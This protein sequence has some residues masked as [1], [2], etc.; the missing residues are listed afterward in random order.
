MM[1]QRGS[2]DTE[3][4]E[5]ACVLCTKKKAS[6]QISCFHQVR[7][8]GSGGQSVAGGECASGGFSSVVSQ[9]LAGNLRHSLSASAVRLLEFH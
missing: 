3:L 9:L 2:S 8:A 6:D 1:G 7:C 5:Q 4:C